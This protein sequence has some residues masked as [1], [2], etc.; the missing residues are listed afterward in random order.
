MQT[1]FE[2]LGVAEDASDEAIKKAYLKKVR[3]YPPDHHVEAFQRIRGAFESIQ[4]EKQRHQYRLFYVDEPDIDSLLRS[5]LR[6]GAIQRPEHDL[7][8]GA[9][10]ET[11]LD[12]LLRALK[13]ADY[14][15]DR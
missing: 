14:R 15:D 6:P 3:E 7:L 9:L 12:T 1:P 4:T 8:A 10:A 2:I 5:A 13:T 11:A